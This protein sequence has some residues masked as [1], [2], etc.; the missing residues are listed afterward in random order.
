MEG[1]DE[2]G[3]AVLDRMSWRSRKRLSDEWG[4]RLR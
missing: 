3:D 2:I 1:F 4:I